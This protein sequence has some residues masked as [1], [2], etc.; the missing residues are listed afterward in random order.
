MQGLGLNQLYSRHLPCGGE[1]NIVGIKIT[2]HQFPC[3]GEGKD[4][5]YCNELVLD[6]KTMKG[7]GLVDSSQETH[8]ITLNTVLFYEYN[9]IRINM[10][11][12]I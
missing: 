2:F 3:R 8:S 9:L 12:Y 1:D 5:W 7:M 10:I 4:I 6:D 11:G